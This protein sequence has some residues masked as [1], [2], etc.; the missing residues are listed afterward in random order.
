IAG[1][2][3]DYR[4][5]RLRRRDVLDTRTWP[6]TWR[7]VGRS[8]RAGIGELSRA[9]LR[10]TLVRA[11]ATYV[12][13]LRTSDV[14]PW[15]AGVRAQALGRDGRLV[16]DFAFSGTGR[17]LHLRNA[18]SPAATSCLAIARHVAAE[19]RRAFA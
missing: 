9:A 1:A 14:E 11:A 7:L 19:A 15:L 2:R 16:D 18:P 4:P 13:D 12:P 10:R 8:W 17:A 3:D 5:G 6:G